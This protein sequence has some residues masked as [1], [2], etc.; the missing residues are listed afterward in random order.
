[1]KIFPNILT[2]MALT[3]ECL[4]TRNM[5][6]LYELIY[7]PESLKKKFSRIDSDA[8]LKCFDLYLKGECNWSLREYGYD[9]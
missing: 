9:T 8:L 2:A 7:E 4:K 5:Q 6:I 1:M 3:C